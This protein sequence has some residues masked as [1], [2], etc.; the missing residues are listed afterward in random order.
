MLEGRSRLRDVGIDEA[1]ELI[2][3]PRAFLV[4]LLE[5][6]EIA[7]RKVGDD[8]RIEEAEL[9]A[10]KERE[11]A[12]RRETTRALTDEARKLGIEY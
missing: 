3:V 1:A 5:S 9:L 10:Y 12:Q 4:A 8:L 11:D 6:G 7:H 2:G